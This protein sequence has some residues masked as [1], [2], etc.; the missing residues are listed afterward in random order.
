MIPDNY[1]VLDKEI[2]AIRTSPT[3]IGLQLTA[4]LSARDFCFISIHDLFDRV[5]KTLDTVDKLEKMDGNLFN[6][7]NIL[8][9]APLEPHYVSSV[10]SGN[11]LG[12]LI[13]LKQGIKDIINKP[14]FSLNNINGI[15]DVLSEVGFEKMDFDIME[16]EKVGIFIKDAIAEIDDKTSA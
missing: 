12:F 13:D 16:I 9:L 7:Y 6:W 1:Q 14:I 15:K 10:D 2:P 4:F 3:N 5:T 11:F 8:T